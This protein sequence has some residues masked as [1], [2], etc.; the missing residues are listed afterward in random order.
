MRQDPIVLQGVGTTPFA[1]TFPRAAYHSDLFATPVVT[2]VTVPTLTPVVP[3]EPNG[4]AVVVA[5]GGAFHALS[6]DSEGFDVATWLAERGVT[7]FVLEYRLVPAEGDAVAAIFAKAPESFD[8]EVAT[9]LPV[10]ID[11]GAT[12]VRTVRERAAEWDV[13]PARVGLIGFS[14]GGSVSRG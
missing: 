9:V 5:P 13:D 12:A 8:A 6:I 11:D 4:T 14:A 2:N 3:D 10:A 1:A 7:A